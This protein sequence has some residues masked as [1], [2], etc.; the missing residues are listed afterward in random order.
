MKHE[1]ALI[2]EKSPYLLQ[3]A[4]DL[5]DWLP[6]GDEAFKTAKKYNKPIFL[7]IGYSTC[8]WC[9]VMARESFND[10]VVA[11]LIN[12]TFVPVKV[13]RE[14]RPDI[15]NIYMNA[16]QLLTGTGGWPLTI[17]LTPDG[18]PFFAGTYFPNETSQGVPGLKEIIF[19]VRELWG[20]KPEDIDNAATEITKAIERMNTP[21]SPQEI[22]VKLVD[23]GFE[24]LEKAFDGENGG[25]GSSQKFPL[26]NH[27]Y[28]LLR[29]GVLRD[30]KALGMVELTLDKMRL[31]GIY[32]QVGY[33]FHRYTIDPSWRIP[34]FEKM[35]YDQA[36]MAIIYLEAYQALGKEL[37][38][39]TANEIFEYVIRE[40]KSPEGGFYSAE[41]AESEGEEGKFYL[42]TMEELKEILDSDLLF[43][44]FNVKKEGNFLDETGK[45]SGKNILYMKT[46]PRK[47][48][49]EKGIE[50]KKFLEEVKDARR[51]L[52]N[53]RSLRT[54]PQK[55]D[56]ILTDW[57]G[58]MIAAFARGYR[59]LQDKRYLDAAR[60]ALEFIM[61]KV[62]DGRL[63]H[64][65]RDGESAI[66]ANLDDYAF[67][68]WGILELY[69]A[70]FNEKYIK[71]ALQLSGELDEHFKDDE[72]GGFFFTAD[73][74]DRLL[75]RKKEGYD[76][77]TPS[78]N[79]VHA[80]NLLKIASILEDETILEAAKAII[81]SFT[82][83]IKR[84]PIAHTL[85]LVGVNWLQTGSTSLVIAAQTPSCIPKKLKNMFIP[86]LTI[87]LKLEDHDWSFAP[88]SLREKKTINGKCTYYL[89]KDRTCHPPIQDQKT[90]IDMLK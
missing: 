68:I 45:P 32:D 69:D 11:K 17:F 66:W 6:W 37:Y 65:Y 38:K 62:Y 20:D 46:A 53:Y 35:L 59:I 18:R 27:L 75:I 43:E 86:Y 71:L 41:D 33:G 42:W 49:E 16:C 47:F 3:H 10:P 74:A 44:F 76:S 13:D 58:L 22:E 30:E 90:L 63:M 83:K 23:R 85:L 64:R 52:F 9:H 25:F 26:A 51:K 84:L 19:K 56:K 78:G 2:K 70:T 14:E 87:T 57:N 50:P 80:I 72:N 1:N 21:T 34:H 73:Y 36:L 8:H 29:Y 81:K 15:D 60:D 4:H 67:L 54:P 79:S 12:E 55:D 7:S 61:D 31:G 82:A 24:E 39:E 77:A 5:V 40:M 89:C 88:K 48:A 28:F